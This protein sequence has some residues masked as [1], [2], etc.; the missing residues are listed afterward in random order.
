[1]GTGRLCRKV[2]REQRNGDRSV[3]V[4]VSFAILKLFYLLYMLI[5][6]CQ[7]SLHFT[8]WNSEIFLA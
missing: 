7:Y 4:F 3:P 2:M 1:M 8:E 5:G 6:H